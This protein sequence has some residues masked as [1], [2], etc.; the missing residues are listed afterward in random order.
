MSVS[1]VEPGE[2]PDEIVLC[3]R[4]ELARLGR[5]N[6]WVEAWRDEVVVFEQSPAPLVISG[7]CPHFGGELD[8]MPRTNTL[9]CRWH[10]WEFD[11]VSGQCRTY[12]I[13]GC[14]RHFR[15]EWRGDKL[16]V[17]RNADS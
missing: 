8:L 3:S 1:A 14:V 17:F 15:H 7:L 11:A 4:Q 5:V 12:P 13:K 2:V 16:V 6:L 9:R 10:G